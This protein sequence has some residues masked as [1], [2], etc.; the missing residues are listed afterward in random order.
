MDMLPCM[1]LT[2]FFFKGAPQLY[3][4]Q[5]SQKSGFSSGKVSYLPSQ[6]NGEGWEG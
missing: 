6:G 2:L 1:V 4:L 5:G 3:K